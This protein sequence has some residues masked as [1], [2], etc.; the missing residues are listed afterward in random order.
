MR[1]AKGIILAFRPFGKTGQAAALTQGANTLASPGD[2][3]M[4]IALVP[5][6]KEQAIG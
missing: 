4:G 1:C 6:I 5:H 2:D 3:F